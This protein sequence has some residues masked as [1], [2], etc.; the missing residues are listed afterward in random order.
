VI[1][2]KR[3]ITALNCFLDKEELQLL[4]SLVNSTTKSINEDF[5]DAE[6]TIVKN[7][8]IKASSKMFF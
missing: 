3:S 6:I 5:L 1:F 2:H 7:Y 4:C 8:L